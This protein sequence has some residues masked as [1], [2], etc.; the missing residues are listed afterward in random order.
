MVVRQEA[1]ASNSESWPAGQPVLP[2]N[3]SRS[4]EASGAQ[5]LAGLT[6]VVTGTLPGFSREEAKELIQSQGG[7]VTDSVSKKTSYLVVGENAGSKLDKARSLGVPI[8]DEAGLRR[9]VENGG[10]NA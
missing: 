2:V 8:L 3:V 5:P 10:S 1:Y 7:K 9:I 4:L 6:F